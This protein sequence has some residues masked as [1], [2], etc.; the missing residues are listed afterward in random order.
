[1]LMQRNA[2]ATHDNGSLR[3]IQ[4]IQDNGALRPIVE[5]AFRYHRLWWLVVLGVILLTIAYTTLAPRQYRSEMDILVQNRR[6]DQQIS[7]DRVNGEITVNGVT[8]EQIN[9]EIQLLMSPGLANTVVDPQWNDPAHQA[10]LNQI[11]LKA[12]DKAVIGFEK[13]LSISMVRKSN[14][15]HAT[16]TSSDPRTATDKLNRLLTAFLAKQREIAQPP[17][18]AKFFADQAASYK[19]QLDQAQQQLAQYQQNQN[20]VSLPD[21]EQTLDRD[22]NEAETNLRMTDAQISEVTKQ[23]GTQTHQLR[24]I[25]D[26]QMTQVR[27]LPNDYSVE[28]LNTMLAELENQRTSL[29]TKFTSN[30]RLVQQVEH[31]ISDTK[32]ALAKAQQMTS[33]EHD[34]D[35]NPVWQSVTGSIIQNETQRQ[36]LKAKHA[37]LA[38][39]IANL[40]KQLS[41]VEGGTVAFS[42]LRQKVTD[43]ENNYQ[44]YTQKRDEAEMAD[45][46]NEN[47]LLNV[48]VAQS[49]TYSVTAFRP[50]PVMDTVLGTFT[51]IFLASFLV[52]FAEMGRGTFAS[53]GEVE[54]ISPYP[55]LATVPLNRVLAARRSGKRLEFAPV[56]IGMASTHAPASERKVGAPSLIKYRRE[57]HIL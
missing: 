56:F 40:Q 2:L 39:Q 50:R 21:T 51:A 44:L 16:Y 29:L 17:G 47:R 6:A 53:S 55:V 35:I 41:G 28:R 10:A 3:P 11:Q 22:I 48:A 25:P 18:T 45:S 4:P 1:M 12:H 43:L 14:V 19:Q 31:Q 9:S 15:I 33:Q 49:P 30:D 20:I 8:E 26:R 24:G 54:R 5:S 42:T 32:A 27:T 7:P 23:L 13:H 46:M 37:A 34:S 36:A 38:D 52:F 57:P